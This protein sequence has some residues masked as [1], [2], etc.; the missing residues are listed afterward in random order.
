MRPK[1]SAANAGARGFAG[2]RT[3]VLALVLLI[4]TLTLA[5]RWVAEHNRAPKNAL[6][7]NS[8][9]ALAALDPALAR[10]PAPARLPFLLK[11]IQDPHPGLRYAAVD[12]L[13]QYHTPEAAAAIESAFRDSASI[14]RQ[15]AVE[16]LHVI[17]RERGLLLLL[18][19]LR[20][21][22]TWIRQT[23]AIQLA[24]RSHSEKP[25]AHTS[26]KSSGSKKVESN[27]QGSAVLLADR[28][29]VPTLI[30]ALGDEDDVVVRHAVAMLR[31]LTGRGLIYR[32]LAGPDAKRRAIRDWKV[33]WDGHPAE[34]TVPAPF[35]DV[36]RIR[37]TRS[38]PAPEFDMRDIGGH[39]VSLASLKGR[40][41][42]LN[43]WG[44]WCPPCRLEIPALERLH[45]R[46]GSRGLTVIG[47]ALSESGGAAGLRTWCA[48]NHVTYRQL[49]STPELQESYG[50]IDEV[51]VSTLIDKLGRVRY[52]WEG[53]RDFPTFQA[54]V[55]RLLRE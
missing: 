37:P 15:R 19:A 2:R 22:D 8:E 6:H 3:L 1:I 20:D 41:T 43:F 4:A 33:W 47:A 7:G 53:D 27:T 29:T 17:D 39:A 13:S 52:R 26:V 25:R 49:L 45:E 35:D 36:A 44:T 14:V 10:M 50:D 40:V 31:S 9:D 54:A 34:F 42:L 23:A 12:G 38:D 48:K 16:T 24:L 55:E 5:G 18:A 28:R 51:P 30:Q 21:E 46:Y 11:S 32:T